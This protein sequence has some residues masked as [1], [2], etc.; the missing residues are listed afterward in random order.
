MAFLAPLRHLWEGQAH[1]GGL[2]HSSR[3]AHTSAVGSLPVAALHFSWPC[4]LATPELGTKGLDLTTRRYHKI[5][6]DAAASAEAT[7][8]D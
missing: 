1:V 2:G 6:T 7:A 4:A 5:L 3:V 8:A